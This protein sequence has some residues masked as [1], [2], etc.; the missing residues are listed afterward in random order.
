MSGSTVVNKGMQA[1][2]CHGTRSTSM[3]HLAASFGR[4]NHPESKLNNTELYMHCRSVVIHNSN[5]ISVS[6][7][8]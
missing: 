4:S 1:K 2:T 7:L 8:I 3:S 5:N 6:N